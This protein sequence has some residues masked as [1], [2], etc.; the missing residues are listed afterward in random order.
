MKRVG[1]PVSNSVDKDLP[2]LDIRTQNAQI[3]D[4][5]RQGRIFASLT[6]GFGLLALILASI[7]IY[8]IM[9]Y[10]VSRRTNEIGIRIA[11]GAERRQVL[12]MVLGESAWIAM[13]GVAAGT[14]SAL[15][16]ARLIASMRYG[17][18]AY[19]PLTFGASRAAAQM[20]SFKR[21]YTHPASVPGEPAT[22][23]MHGKLVFG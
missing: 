2:L 11:L 14:I 5:T 7:G 16:L 9:A 1:S 10:S 4:R 15:I 22:P 6:S 20:R 12:R 3:H 21:G 8:G 23:V 18:K 17:L 13:I 19:D